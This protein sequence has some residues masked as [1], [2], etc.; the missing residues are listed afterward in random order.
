MR[1]LLAFLILH[2]LAICHADDTPVF[3]WKSVEF[4]D[5]EKS[6]TVG[7]YASYVASGNHVSGIGYHARSG[8]MIVT[9]PRRQ[10]GIPATVGAFCAKDWKKGSSPK[11]FPIPNGQLNALKEGFFSEAKEMTSADAVS[12]KARASGDD[13]KPIISVSTPIIDNKCNRL[14][15]LDT[16]AIWYPDQ[17]IVVHRPSMWVV[18]LPEKSCSKDAF[19]VIK[20]IEFS[21]DEVGDLSGLA[22]L[23]LD[24]AK[25][26]TCDDVHV[27]MPDSLGR[28]IVV[29]DYRKGKTWAFRGHYSFD[30][31]VRESAI[32]AGDNQYVI[33]EGINSLT[34]GWRDSTDYRAAYYIPLSGTGQFAVSTQ[35]LKDESRAPGNFHPEDFRLIGY[36]GQQLQA[37]RHVFDPKTGIIFYADAQEQS[38]R[39]WN[40]R[41]P[42]TPDH[43]GVTNFNASDIEGLDISVS[44]SIY[45]PYQQF[46]DSSFL[47]RLTHGDSCGFWPI[48]PLNSEFQEWTPKKLMQRYSVFL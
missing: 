36:R 20:R 33:E 14:W 17:I 27:Y 39:C 46:Y 42:L 2:L 15:F 13:L 12:R 43:V 29:H 41:R 18:Q 34:L 16:G 22:D 32:V 48:N 4:T 24:F 3:S 7:G 26:G 21:D 44:F 40:V 28:Q 38:I 6:T 1:V 10:P 30:P 47:D 37:N 45:F 8:S 19:K 31:I 35:V 25:N 9:I 5:V 23:A 11:I